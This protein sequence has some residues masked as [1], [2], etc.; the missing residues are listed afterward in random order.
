MQR[1]WSIEVTA[2]VVVVLSLL[3]AFP[4]AAAEEKN[5]GPK[6]LQVTLERLGELLADLDAELASIDRPASE[7]LE[8]HVEEAA[9]L[10]EELL[11]SFGGDG[12]GPSARPQAARLDLTLHQ[13]IALLNSV[14]G[15][16]GQRPERAKARA[17]LG[18]LGSWVDGYVARAT[19]GMTAR[20]AE[21]FDR[22]A[23][24]LAHALAAHLARVAKG[25]AQ[26]PHPDA[27]TQLQFIQRL[28]ILTQRLDEILLHLTAAPK[29]DA[30]SP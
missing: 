10:V 7:R 13:L 2:L 25:T 30:T 18:E 22:A 24:G 23:H 29:P 27:P 16:P 17:T 28:E 20:E 6:P 9:G 15:D 14:V 1:R 4:V 12:P 19:A 21:R 8:L 11:V 26:A 3:A 5:A